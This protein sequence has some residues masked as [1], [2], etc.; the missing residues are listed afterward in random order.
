MNGDNCE[1]LSPLVLSCNRD[2]NN[3]L[4]DE[5]VVSLGVDVLEVAGLSGEGLLDSSLLQQE[6]AGVT[7]DSPGNIRR[8]HLSSLKYFNL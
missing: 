6:A 5:S 8:N 7:D 2:S 1:F 4:I 3:L